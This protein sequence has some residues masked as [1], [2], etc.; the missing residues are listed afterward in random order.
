MS[1]SEFVLSAVV[2][3]SVVSVLGNSAADP[4]SSPASSFFNHVYNGY[5]D[6]NISLTSKF[7]YFFLSFAHIP[8]REDR[9]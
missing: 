8:E 3:S 5:G 7:L 4:R 9:S 1:C 2:R 6:H